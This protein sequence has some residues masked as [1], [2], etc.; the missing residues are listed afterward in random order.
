MKLTKQFT[1]KCICDGSVSSDNEYDVLSMA[2]SHIKIYHKAIFKKLTKRGKELAR[3][4]IGCGYGGD[5]YA[6]Q[7]S[8]RTAW[9]IKAL[10][11]MLEKN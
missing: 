6:A 7:S 9:T 4:Q 2:L 5:W 10:K 3:C 8:F 11:E 1:F